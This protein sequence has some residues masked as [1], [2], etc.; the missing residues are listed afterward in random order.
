MTRVAVALLWESWMMTRWG[1]LSRLLV[2]LAFIL[3][4]SVIY[5]T[6]DILDEAALDGLRA[7][8]LMIVLLCAFSGLG[9][10]RS[11]DGRS[12]FPFYLGFSRPVPTWLQVT[13]PMAYRTV[14]CTALYVIPVLVIH[15]AYGMANLWILA[16]LLMIPITL[17]TIASSWWTDKKGISQLLGW[18]TVISCTS[19][20]FYYTLHF[21]D[22]T[23]ADD[24]KFLWMRTFLFSLQD[25]MILLLVSV[26]AIVLTLTGVKSQRHGDQGLGSWKL[27]DSASHQADS[28]WLAELYQ[29][30]CPT[31]S[32]KRAELWSEINGRGLPAFMLSLIVALTIPMFWFLSHL[33]GFVIIFWVV[34]IM[35]SHI[36]L[37]SAPTL[38]IVTKQGS[39]Y[40]ST[41]DATRPLNTFW[42]AGMKLGVASVSML[43]GMLV[44]AI[45]FWFSV[46]LVEGFIDGIEIGKQNI[47]NYFESMPIV[48][49][50]LLIFVRLVQFCTMV[51]FLATLQTT[52]A[53]YADRITFGVLWF[54]GYACAVPIMLA[55]KVLP[56]SFALGHVWLWLGL[57][58][59]GAWYFLHFMA[60]NS[61]M[62]P[63]QIAA[64]VILWILYALAYFYRLRD[65]DVFASD[66]PVEFIVFQACICL[67]P[68]VILAMA[69][70]SLAMTRHR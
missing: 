13:V 58:I 11:Q 16:G 53:L 67:L 32:A 54:I 6:R 68:L 24:P 18:V 46:P 8:C 31:T 63:G 44:I 30:E 17:M 15:F 4:F 55:T 60:K 65:D 3:L 38:G 2:A 25:Y 36:P 56:V 19:A 57:M 48:E 10:G 12:G 49:L 47:L 33:T 5:E 64:L 52:Y 41:F 40:M 28:D 69:P 20:L 39:A 37:A 42:L 70:W 29:S 27:G 1:Y 7:L 62:R 21:N 66:T 61:I 45:S 14:F 50:V 9:L 51:A 23:V 59:A 22:H 35:A 43:S 34:T 26:T